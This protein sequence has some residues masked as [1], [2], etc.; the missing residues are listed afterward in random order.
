MLRHNH[1]LYIKE[2][3]KR[4]NDIKVFFNKESNIK[5]VGNYYYTVLML[6]NNRSY[7]RFAVAVKRNKAKAVKRNK[8]KRIVR[9]I[10]RLEKDNIPIGYDYFIIV[11]K[12]DIDNSFLFD[13]VRKNL[14]DLLQKV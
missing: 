7:S 10:Y 6:K 12:I 11:N 4:R 2:R 9:E 5:R 1:K 13:N 8:A 14:L 3:L